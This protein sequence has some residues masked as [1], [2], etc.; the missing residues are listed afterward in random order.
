MMG[1]AAL[2]A[3][4][5]QVALAIGLAV[6]ALQC[7][8]RR[9][10]VLV[11]LA[12]E[13]LAVWPGAAAAVAPERCNDGRVICDRLRVRPLQPHRLRRQQARN[14]FRCQFLHTFQMHKIQI[15]T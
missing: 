15:Q 12:L 13:V 1:A 11:H 8:Q 7:Q 4:A 6:A 14:C 5:H 10:V 9:H 2:V 3:A